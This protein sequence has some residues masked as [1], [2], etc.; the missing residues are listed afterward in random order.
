MPTHL[1][2]EGDDRKRYSKDE[3]ENNEECVEL[4]ICAWGSEPVE[5]QPRECKAYKIAHNWHHKQCY[6]PAESP[7]SSIT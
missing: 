4:T 2:M 1:G 3:G 7:N 5:K 6:V